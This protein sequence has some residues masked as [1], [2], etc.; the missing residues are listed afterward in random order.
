MG[1]C[2][3]GSGAAALISSR[4]SNECR[5]HRPDHIPLAPKGCCVCC[6]QVQHSPHGH[7]QL[8]SSTTGNAPPIQAALH[9]PCPAPGCSIPSLHPQGLLNQQSPCFDQSH[10]TWHNIW[11]RANG[12]TCSTGSLCAQ[13][14]QHLKYL[15]PPERLHASVL[16]HLVLPSHRGWGIGCTSLCRLCLHPPPS[17]SSCAL[18]IPDTSG[19]LC[20]AQCLHFGG[21]EHGVWVA[22][23]GALCS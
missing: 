15:P 21:T 18:L 3:A 7:R 14:L 20:D 5:K 12:P 10:S 4:T 11:W 13:P 2:W 8:L 17:L 23:G 22:W 16:H 9:S 6:S 19:M 1:P